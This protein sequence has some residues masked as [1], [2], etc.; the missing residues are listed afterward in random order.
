MQ[1]IRALVTLFMVFCFITYV[2]AQ[3]SST[4]VQLTDDEKRFDFDKNGTLN[5]EENALMLQVI[6][7]ETFSGSKLS[8]EE[9]KRM[10]GALIAEAGN[11]PPIGFGGGP[12]SGRRGRG[13]PRPAVKIVS[14]FDT[15]KDGKLTGEERKAA[16]ESRGDAYQPGQVA[17]TPKGDIESDIKEST[18][19]TPSNSPSFYNAQ[20]LRTLY[21]RFHDEDW[22]SQLNAFYRTDVEVP[23]ELVVDGKVY[24]E[25]GVRARGTSS[26]FTVRSAKK[27]FNIA[28]DYGDDGQ[29]LFGYKTLNLLNG[30]VDSSFIR[31]VLYN[32]IAGDY[33]PS[34]K[35]NLVKLVINGEN[36]GV[37]I[38]LQQYNKDFLEEWF[39]T[40]D[41]IRWKIG[42]GGG[43]LTYNGDDIARYQNTY[44]LKTG[45]VENPWE[46]LIELC[47]MLDENT[48][49]SKLE[50]D[51][52]SI[53][54]I[55]RALWQLAVSNVFMDDDSYIHK[56]GDFSLYKDTNDR[57]HLI[58]HDNNE[59]FRFGR[60]PRGGGG[61]GPGGGGPRGW[62][63]GELADGMAT[64][65]THAENPLRP[66]ISRLVGVPEWKARYIAHVK[67][68]MNEWLDWK[69]IEPIILEYHDL[70]DTEVQQDDKKLYSYDDFVNS[71]EGEQGGRTP[72]YKQFITRRREYLLNHPELTK[73]TPKIVSVS[74][75]ENPLAGETVEITTQLDKMV[76]PDKVLLYYSI[77][78]HGVFSK[79]LMSKRDDNYTGT[80][81]VYPA[82][83]T[84]YY[85]VEANTVKTHGTTAFYPVKT[86]FNPLHYRVIAPQ[87]IGVAVVINELMAANTNSIVDPQGDYEDWIELHNTSNET[88]SL[89]GMYLSD[90]M[91]NLTKWEFPDLSTIPPKGYIIVWL[92]EDGKADEGLHANFK[93]SR[94]GETVLLVDTD[95]RGNK[96]IDS[97][98]FTELERDSAFGRSPNATGTFQELEMTP[99]K[100]NQVK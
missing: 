85:Y 78:K 76:A 10:G 75:P 91:D 14:Q 63:W 39:D 68:V 95:E 61:G 50:T 93:L 46:K 97:I 51:L 20:T 23:A 86:E 37:Y 6:N 87:A 100:K 27:S 52:S 1:Q 44:Q 47:K 24:S 74:S 59:T 98:T 29:R 8:D 42:P 25:V 56:G 5:P 45:N 36:W 33:I 3:D 62:S 16:L 30:H 57:F 77:D 2:N 83:T 53:F 71:V 4:T 72:S 12:P 82:G 96:V 28:I 60:E 55:D 66:V 67:T 80:I 13:G 70:I 21:L 34:M 79:T 64:P 11:N 94:N 31:E 54:N 92:D 32:R 99:G 17:G 58:S 90:K 81:P 9:I 48:P 89:A 18:A 69:K 26:Y 19:S 73:P 38:N 84:V 49:D 22:Y 15:N 88:V 41:G 35:T 40:R 43:A 65:L 7:I